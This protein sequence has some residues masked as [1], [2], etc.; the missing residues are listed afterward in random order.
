MVYDARSRDK[1]RYSV[2][3]GVTGIRAALPSA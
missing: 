1:R 3:N 2:T